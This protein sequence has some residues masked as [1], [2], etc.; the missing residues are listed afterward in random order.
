MSGST[1]SRRVSEFVGVALFAAALIWII[2]A[3]QLRADRPGLV[4]QHRGARARRP[5]SP[6]ASARSSPS[7]RSSC[8]ATRRTSIPAVLVVVGWNYFWCRD[9]RRGRHE[10]DRRRAA[11]RAASAR[12]SASSSARSTSPASRSAPAAT[13]A[14]G[15]RGEMSEYLNRTGSIIV[16][17]TLIVLADHHVDAVLVRPAVRAP[18]LGAA[19]RAGARAG[20]R[21]RSG[22][23]SG[24][25]RS[26]GAR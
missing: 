7:C 15:S 17:L 9:A 23:K 18:S 5:T 13:S 2:V 12:S 26:S 10:G 1:V 20:R 6:A 4:L 16:V 25:A 14:S 19:R 24:G 22:G 3:R 8:S 21:S 11:L